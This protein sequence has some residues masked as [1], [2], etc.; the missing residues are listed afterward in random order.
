[1][2]IKMSKVYDNGRGVNIFDVD[3]D[4][5]ITIPIIIIFFEFG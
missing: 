2:K 1:M 5:L 4:D 3:D